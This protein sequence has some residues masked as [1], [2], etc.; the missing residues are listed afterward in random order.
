MPNTKFKENIFFNIQRNYF[1][2]QTIT[3]LGGSGEIRE[4]TNTAKNFAL[5]K[6][7]KTF[8]SNNLIVVQCIVGSGK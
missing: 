1:E 6:R 3:F 4:T 2:I 5:L 8:S 7:P